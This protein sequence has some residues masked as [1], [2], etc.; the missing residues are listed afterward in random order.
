MWT[1]ERQI[2]AEVFFKDKVELFAIEIQE[3]ALGEEVEVEESIGTFSCN[4]ESAT[5]AY[6][7]TVSGVSV[8]QSIRISLA[9]D[10]PL[11]NEK[12][13]KLK[14]IEARITYDPWE[15]W[16]VQGF[17]EGQISTVI[18]AQREVSL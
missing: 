15:T 3:T 12:R 6:K 16:S 1:K 2:V 9:K 8:P 13:Y 10:T 4:I 14:I 11:T 18:T 17:V 7:E 5:N